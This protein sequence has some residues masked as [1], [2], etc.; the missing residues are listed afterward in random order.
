MINTL[1]NPLGVTCISS[2]PEPIFLG[3]LATALGTINLQ[4]ASLVKEDAAESDESGNENW[5]IMSEMEIKAHQNGIV[6]MCISNDGGF[7]A[8]ASEKG[9][10]IR[11]YKVSSGKLLKEFRRGIKAV[12]ITGLTFSSDNSLLLV[13]SNTGTIHLFDLTSG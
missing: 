3:T 7:V 2:A 8:T 1:E 4:R 10:L 5:E 12:M 9:T 11:V 13:S 6:A